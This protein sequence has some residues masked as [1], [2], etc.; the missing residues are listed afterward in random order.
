MTFNHCF[1]CEFRTFRGA[2]A[3]D[4]SAALSAAATVLTVYAVAGSRPAKGTNVAH[5]SIII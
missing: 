3:S 2:S 1:L 5:V 4:M